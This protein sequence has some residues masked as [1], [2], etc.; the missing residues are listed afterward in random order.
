MNDHEAEA[1]RIVERFLDEDHAPPGMQHAIAA[2][3][4]AAREAGRDAER[5]RIAKLFEKG[6]ASLLW[7]TYD[8]RDVAR[9]IRALARPAKEPPSPG[10]EGTCL[11]CGANWTSDCPVCATTN[12]GPCSA[13]GD[14]RREESKGGG[15]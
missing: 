11:V 9:R 6:Q 4:A 14:A 8:G 5:E 10:G 2:A 12:R 7:P 15:V 1:R 3:L 13:P